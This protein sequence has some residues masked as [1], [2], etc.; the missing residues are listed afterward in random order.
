MR[1]LRLLAL[2]LVAAVAMPAEAT[3]CD[4]YEFTASGTLTAERL[5]QRIRQTEACING[6][7]GNSNWSSTDL[8]QNSY[9][10]SP[11]AIYA[12]S[13]TIG[14]EDADATAGEQVGPLATAL[15]KWHVQAAGQIIGMSVALRCPDDVTGTAGDCTGSAQSVTVTLKKGASTVKSFTA[16]ADTNVHTDLALASTI[17]TTDDLTIELGGTV[18]DVNFVDIVVYT[19]ALHL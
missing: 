5:N 17:A 8:L 6:G 18:T 7:I 16:L 10:A 19:K 9:L 11:N 2:V 13:W 3:T 15:R 4:I 12:Q 1:A 14:D